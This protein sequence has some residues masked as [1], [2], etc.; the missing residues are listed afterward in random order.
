MHADPAAWGEMLAA[1]YR[2]IGNHA[3]RNLPIFNETLSVEA[4]GFRL[5]EGR[6]IGIM[7]TPWFMNVVI[8]VP[9]GASQSFRA[10]DTH[11]LV[12][13]PA[14]DIQFTVS[15]VALVGPIASCSLL[16]PM[17]GF[18]DMATACATAEAALAA[19][20]SA[21][22]TAASHGR[23]APHIRSIDRRHFLQGLLTARRR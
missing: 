22:D 10:R 8:P 4:V 7:V 23:D 5:H 2:D 6:V 18:E 9:D 11:L 13:F 3:V 17:F 14:G 16:S 15:E 12:R 20:M 21:A 1:A 19:L